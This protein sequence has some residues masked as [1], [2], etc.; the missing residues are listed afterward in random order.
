M[1]WGFGI[2]V[3]KSETD[4]ALDALDK[5][6]AQPEIIGKVTDSPQKITIKHGNKKI[7]LA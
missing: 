4:K 6:N 3:D 2:I 7:F 5:A 1:G